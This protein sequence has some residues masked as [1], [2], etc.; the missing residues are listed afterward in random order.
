VDIRGVIEGL[1]D[2]YDADHLVQEMTQEDT[3]P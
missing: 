2:V 3:S 1:S